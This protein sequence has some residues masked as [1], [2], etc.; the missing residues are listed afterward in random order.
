MKKVT[1]LC[2]AGACNRGICYIGSL[3]KLQEDDL[4]DLKQVV[5]VSIGSLIATGILLGY[6]PL[7]MLD[8]IIKKDT[9]EFKDISMSGHTINILK[10]HNYR[11]WVKDIIKNKLISNNWIDENINSASI[12]DSAS[13]SASGSASDSVDNFTLLDLFNK[14][15]VH[16][17]V[18]VACIHSSDPEFNEGLI[19]LDHERYPNFPLITAINASMAFPFIFPPV[20]YSGCQFVDGGLIDNFP[21]DRVSEDALALRVNFGDINGL[22]SVKSPVS[23]MG[24]LFQ[25]VTAR[26]RQLQGLAKKDLTSNVVIVQCD[27]FSLIDFEM[28]VDDKI[29]LFK[30]GYK[31]IEQY[32]K[33]KIDSSSIITEQKETDKVGTEV[34]TEVETEKDHI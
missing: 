34:E 32:I 28:S 24:K 19:H 1:S 5:A 30:R 4:L 14:T 11:S 8:L 17:T 22:E 31:A 9:K 15:G 26:M 2:L 20:S 3:L 27:D 29:T 16:F 23:Y 6:T 18:C 13:V 21:L 10:G 25:L 12:V 33:T 7:E